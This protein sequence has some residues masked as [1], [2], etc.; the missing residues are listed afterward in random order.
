MGLIIWATHTG[1]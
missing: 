1:I